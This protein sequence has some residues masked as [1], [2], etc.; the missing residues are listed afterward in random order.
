MKRPELRISPTT[1]KAL[2]VHLGEA[3]GMEIANLL[4]SL[5]DRVAQLERSKVS[6]THVAPRDSVNLL[7]KL[8]DEL[9]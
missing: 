2:C 6:V 3:A 9:T 7:P 1:R 8:V 4:Q 5:A